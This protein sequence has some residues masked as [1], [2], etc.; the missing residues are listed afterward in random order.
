MIEINFLK[1]KKIK[2]QIVTKQRRTRKTLTEIF[3][4][5]FVLKSVA[6]GQNFK[7]Q[8]GKRYVFLRPIA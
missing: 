4:F 1:M 8:L 6:G 3:L 7:P 5:D 2:W